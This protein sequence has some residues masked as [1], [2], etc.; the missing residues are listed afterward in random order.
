MFERACA[1]LLGDRIS[2]SS[3]G[4]GTVTPPD[5]GAQV[6]PRSGMRKFSSARTC[7][8]MPGAVINP[9]RRPGCQQMIAEKPC[10]FALNGTVG[11]GRWRHQ[12]RLPVHKLPAIAGDNVRI[13]GQELID[14]HARRHMLSKCDHGR[15]AIS[16]PHRPPRLGSLARTRYQQRRT[17]KEP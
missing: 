12:Y 5:G 6:T 1:S 8:T 14:G 9:A 16:F 3:T 17:S 4:S 15:Y 13:P 7:G 11:F 10:K 2:I